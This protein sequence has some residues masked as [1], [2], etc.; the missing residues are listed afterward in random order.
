MREAR[1]GSLEQD[2]G[3]IMNESSSMRHLSI[4]GSLT[5]AFLLS[6]FLLPVWATATGTFAV[7]VIA[8]TSLLLH[9]IDEGD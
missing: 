4:V 2:R 6:L 1:M 7:L 8:G 9:R 5:V 3:D